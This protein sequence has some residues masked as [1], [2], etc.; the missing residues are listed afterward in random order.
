M[1]NAKTLHCIFYSHPWATLLL[2]QIKSIR[3]IDGVLIELS[4]QHILSHVIKTKSKKHRYLTQVLSAYQPMEGGFLQ[5]FSGK[6]ED[7]LQLAREKCDELPA[8]IIFAPPQISALNQIAA[9]KICASQASLYQQLIVLIHYEEA[10]AFAGLYDYMDKFHILWD[11]ADL[12]TAQLT[13]LTQL[14]VNHSL[15]Q[16]RWGGFHLCHHPR[17]PV[18]DKEQRYEFFESVIATYPL[19]T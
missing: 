14:L 8:P 9:L 5:F 1:S 2:N 11:I 4:N 15:T 19:N 16:Q 18:A 10:E 13:R 17:R 7:A 12:P 6:T 3:F